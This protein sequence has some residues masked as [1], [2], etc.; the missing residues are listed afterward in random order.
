MAACVEV[1]CKVVVEPRMSLENYI[2]LDWLV[3]QVSR[4]SVIHAIRW[5]CLG[6]R[7]SSAVTGCHAAAGILV[8]L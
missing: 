3:G 6:C 8:A 2:G 1:V 5:P 4:L 7:I